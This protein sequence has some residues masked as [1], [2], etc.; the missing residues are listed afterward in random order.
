MSAEGE[1]WIILAL[2]DLAKT[3][4]FLCINLAI[5]YYG[6]LVGMDSVENIYNWIDSRKQECIKRINDDLHKNDFFAYNYF[7]ID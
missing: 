5:P 3:H 1:L 6:T 7:S 2:D 4:D